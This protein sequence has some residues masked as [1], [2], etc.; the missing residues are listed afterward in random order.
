MFLALMLLLNGYQSPDD[1][2]AEWMRRA[3]LRSTAALRGN[4]RRSRLPPAASLR[5]TGFPIRD[6]TSHKVRMFVDK[7]ERC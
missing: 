4:R 3:A 7:R 2:I 5:T 6:S 1:K